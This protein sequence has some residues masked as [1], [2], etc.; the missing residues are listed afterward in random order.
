MYCVLWWYELCKIT[1][2]AVSVQNIFSSVVCLLPGYCTAG[3]Y[4]TPNSFQ[5]EDGTWCGMCVCACARVRACAR[6]VCTSGLWHEMILCLLKYLKWIDHGLMSGTTPVLAWR[7]WSMFRRT[8]IS[9]FWQHAKIW[10][11]YLWNKK[12]ECYPLDHV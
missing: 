4:E 6:N 8:F 2:A 9:L 5:L 1:Q 3:Y 12:E 7:D 10:T 11:H